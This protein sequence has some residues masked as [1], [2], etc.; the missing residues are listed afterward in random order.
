MKGNPI[1]RIRKSLIRDVI[2]IL[3]VI[4]WRAKNGRHRS[5]AM[6]AVHR[7]INKQQRDQ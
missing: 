6:G 2:K 7:G 1:S 5:A 4:Q 3:V